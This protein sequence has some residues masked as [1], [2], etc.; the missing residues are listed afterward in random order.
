[1]SPGIFIRLLL[2]GWLTFYA[3]FW[4]LGACLLSDSLGLGL[5]TVLAVLPATFAAFLLAPWMTSHSR[6]LWAR[7]NMALPLAALLLMT[8]VLWILYLGWMESIFLETLGGLIMLSFGQFGTF[9]LAAMVAGMFEL[10]AWKDGADAPAAFKPVAKALTPLR[11]PVL[12][13]IAVPLGVLLVKFLLLVWGGWRLSD[14]LQRLQR[15]VRSGEYRYGECPTKS[16]ELFAYDPRSVRMVEERFAIRAAWL[17]A[18]EKS[19]GN[20]GWWAKLPE[21]RDLNRAWTRYCESGS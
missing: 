10:A 8:M 7:W 12:L 20:F 17:S 4:V 19:R 18:Q 6:G 5:V 21:Q 14:D 9:V 3:G 11:L 1:M 2:D 16:P 13:L 15:Q